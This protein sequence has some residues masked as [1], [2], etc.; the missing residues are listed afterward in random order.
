MKT[1]RRF[2][3]G[4]GIADTYTTA[5]VIGVVPAL[6]VATFH[7]PV[8]FWEPCLLLFIILALIILY[9]TWLAKRT[10]FLSPGERM[11]GR[12]LVD[13]QKQWLNLFGINR[14]GLFTLFFFSLML[15]GNSW[16]NVTDK[17]VYQFFTYPRILWSFLKVCMLLLGLTFV[18]SGRMKGGFFIVAFYILTGI[19]IFLEP[20]PANFP[21]VIARGLGVFNLVMA[22]I[23]GFILL[24]YKRAAKNKTLQPLTANT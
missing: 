24:W 20:P 1:G 2:S 10:T 13:G 18:G 22:F 3:W 6:Y 23:A 17:A 11:M 5:S 19:G 12:I 14:S 8:S 21:M 15:I 7:R 16:D 9:H 4:A